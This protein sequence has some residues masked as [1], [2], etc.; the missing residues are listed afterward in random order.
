MLDLLM[1]FFLG[2]VEG[3]TEFIPVSSTAHLIVLVEGLNF[4]APPGHFFEIFIQLGAIMAVIFHYRQKLWHTVAHCW[5][6]QES[7]HF[8]S[9]LALGTIPA[10]IVGFLGRDWIK[11]HLYNPQV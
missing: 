2:V 8:V 9:L 4:P 10:L 6:E 1:A 11:T 5:H 7:R 3:L